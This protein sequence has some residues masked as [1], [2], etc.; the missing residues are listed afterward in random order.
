VRKL[1]HY[2]EA[3]KTY[4]KVNPTHGLT[5][6]MSG[7]WNGLKDPALLCHVRSDLSAFW[8][9]FDDIADEYEFTESKEK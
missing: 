5:I 4:E 6:D 1:E 3:I 8:R 9:I 2:Q 7:T